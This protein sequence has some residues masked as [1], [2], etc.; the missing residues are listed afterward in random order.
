MVFLAALLAGMIGAT[1]CGGGA[2]PRSTEAD[3]LQVP[4]IMDLSDPQAPIPVD[5]LMVPRVALIVPGDLLQL[6]LLG[7]TEITGDYLV[8]RDGKINLPLLGTVEA[9]GKSIDSLDTEITHG[10]NQYYRFADIAV[11]IKDAAPRE[12]FV[13][14]EVNNP[15]RHE[16]TAG[17]RILHGLAM[18]GGMSRQ[19]RS[20]NVVLM[21]RMPDG[22]EHAYRLAFNQMQSGIYPQDIYLQAGDVIFVPRTRFFTFTE[23]AGEFLNVLSRAATTTLIID[24]LVG[25]RTRALTVGR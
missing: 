17:D 21:R 5:Q 11:N 15:G 24:D 1:G 25:L 22:A 14:G 23:Y 7:H 4:G 10:L 20:D 6:D 13:L 8:T 12:I 9:A 19:A 18:A 3:S 2:E 16:F